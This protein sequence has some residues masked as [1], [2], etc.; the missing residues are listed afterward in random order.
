MVQRY[1]ISSDYFFL[2]LLFQQVAAFFLD[3]E[4]ITGNK[5]ISIKRNIATS[6]GFLKMM[7]NSF[8]K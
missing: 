1:E 4:I 6:K 3:F 5:E 2:P 8:R 7:M